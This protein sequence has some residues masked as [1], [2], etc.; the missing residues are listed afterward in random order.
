MLPVDPGFGHGMSSLGMTVIIPQYFKRRRGRAYAV[1]NAGVCT[2]QMLGPILISHLLQEYGFTGA[3]L[4]VAAMLLNICV[5]A[6]VF[7][8]VEWHT[9]RQ[10]ADRNTMN[11]HPLD[12]DSASGCGVTLLRTIRTLV[13]SFRMLASLR[14][15]IIVMGASLNMSGYLTFFSMLP[16][17]MADDGYSHE[18]VSWC[19][20]VSGVCNLVTRVVVTT[21][22]DWPRFSKRGCFMAGTATI[23]L[24]V[25]E[26]QKNYAALCEAQDNEWVCLYVLTVE[27]H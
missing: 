26:I 18:E 7:Q 1:M 9:T 13:S 15:L 16:F 3:V 11:D 12:N 6:C 8:P 23:A 5:A 21:L 19:M 27:E 14:L 17:I 20:S 2:G 4:I 10:K 25:V 24:T 22:A